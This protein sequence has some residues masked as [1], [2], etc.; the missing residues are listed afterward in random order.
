MWLPTDSGAAKASRD[1]GSFPAFIEHLWSVIEPTPYVEGWHFDLMAEAAV[2][3]VNGLGGY[4]SS[5]R[6]RGMARA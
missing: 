6:R 4:W 1:A 3:M 2:G 5:T